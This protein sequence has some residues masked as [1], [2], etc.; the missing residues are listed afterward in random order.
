MRPKLT[1]YIP[2]H[3]DKIE[4]ANYA[5]YIDKTKLIA[6]CYLGKS[7]RPSFNYRFK[8]L[9]HLEKFVSEM[10]S[11]YDANYKA[12]AEKKQILKDLNETFEVKRYFE[13]GDIVQNTWGYEQTNQEFYQVVKIKSKKQIVVREICQKSIYHEGFSSMSCHVMPDT[14]NF[15]NDEEIVLTVKA[16]T[17]EPFYHICNSESF[18]YFHKFNGKE[19]YK[20]WYA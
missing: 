20:S 17:Y 18:Y 10:L 11:R 9:E 13:I 7:A 16:C 4:T 3:T 1:R 6:T 19:Q 8:T 14:D 15:L 5:C 2:E 12:D